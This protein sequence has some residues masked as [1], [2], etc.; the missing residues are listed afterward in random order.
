MQL[1]VTGDKACPSDPVIGMSGPENRIRG[2]AGHFH[3]EIK[4]ACVLVL[5]A[6]RQVLL[7][8]SIQSHLTAFLCSQLSP[9]PKHVLSPGFFQ[10]IH[11]S[12][13]RYFLHS[14][15]TYWV[16]GKCQHCAG[17]WEYTD[18]QGRL[19]SAIRAYFGGTRRQAS[20]FNMGKLGNG[21]L[22][23]HPEFLPLPF[24]ILRLL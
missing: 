6:L 2:V 24:L 3:L 5:P 22:P 9:I 15:Y 11:P 20:T 19:V 23:T 10:N 14:T 12:I 8:N 4:L 1:L 21:C 17:H 16:L 18:G 13:I 7:L